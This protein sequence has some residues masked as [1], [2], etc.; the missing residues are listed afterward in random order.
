MISAT[1]LTVLTAIVILCAVWNLGRQPHPPPCKLTDIPLTFT[2]TYTNAML[3]YL[4]THW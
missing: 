1:V 4:R 2:L 3:A